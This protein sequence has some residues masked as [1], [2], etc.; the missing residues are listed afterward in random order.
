MLTE[1]QNNILRVIVEE[2][3]KMAKPVS[4]S[5]IC[6]EINCSSATVR[7]EMVRLEELGFLEKD[8]FASGRTPSEEGY[9]YY[10]DNLMKPKDM[11]GEDMLKLQTIFKNN[12]L[13]LSDTIRKS[14]EIVS[15]ITN[16]TSIV[17]GSSAK[18]NK[19]KKV[20]VIPLD[21]NKILTM[22]ITDKGV[23][24]HKN[25]YL[26]N[27]ISMEEV[28]KTV[29]LI[30]K[31]IVGTPINEV[32]EKL[33]YE[34]KPIIGKYV[35]QHE[36]LYNAFYDAFSEFSS[37]NNEVHFVGRNNFLKQPEFENIDKVKKLLSKFEDV[38][39]IREE[40]NNGINIYIG[41]DSEISDDVSVIKTKYNY[42]GE[43]GTI[44]IVGPK[45][46]EY[47]RVVSLLDYIKENIGGRDE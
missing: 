23:V 5:K 12:S 6:K 17:L 38:N 31:L 11:T 46:M 13:A 14:I 19:L 25:L 33:E 10:V 35:K 9:K 22:V 24:E 20:E 36:V 26:P 2:Y 34:I 8:H 4:S 32:S 21:E 47:D 18:D 15:E 7:N 30:N 3:V 1:R 40:E 37:N 27:T 39:S 45:R 29:E 16:Y 43:E 44:A 41:K 28:S 42:N